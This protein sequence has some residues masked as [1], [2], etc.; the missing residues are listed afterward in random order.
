MCAVL[1]SLPLADSGKQEGVV[2]ASSNNHVFIKHVSGCT[3]CVTL[4]AASQCSH[5]VLGLIHF[6]FERRE[7]SRKEIFFFLSISKRYISA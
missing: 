4:T 2:T 1:W 5:D 3:T 6:L 7:L